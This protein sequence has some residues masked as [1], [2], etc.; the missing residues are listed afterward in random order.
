MERSVSITDKRQA[1]TIRSAIHY[2]RREWGTP[3]IF[4]GALYHPQDLWERAY[5]RTRRK[6]PVFKRMHPNVK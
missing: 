5:S 6:D 4:P 1:A 2:A 3:L